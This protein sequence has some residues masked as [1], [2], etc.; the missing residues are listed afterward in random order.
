MSVIGCFCPL[1]KIFQP[2]FEVKKEDGSIE[3]VTTHMLMKNPERI[4]TPEKFSVLVAR[5]C[6]DVKFWY[7]E[8]RYISDV[9][10]DAYLSGGPDGD[11]KQETDF[12]GLVQVPMDGDSMG[13]LMA[14]VAAG[15][16][17]SESLESRVKKSQSIAKDISEKRVMRQIRSTLGHL[18][19]ER[20]RLQEEGKGAYVPSPVEFLCTYALASEETQN[21]D[22]LAK[23]TESF[24]SLMNKVEQSSKTWL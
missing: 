1:A 11:W 9:D 24:N 5:S 16:K 15:G 18:K 22:E 3:V 21:A 2:S 23:I 20:E 6:G 19:K 8:P 14:Q 7:G 4:R 12:S 17:T 10:L 13:E